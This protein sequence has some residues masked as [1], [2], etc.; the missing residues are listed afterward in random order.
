V[1]RQNDAAYA[2][3]RLTQGDKEETVKVHGKL[4]SNDGQ[5][6]IGWALDGHGI[7]MRA[8]WDG[9]VFKK[10]SFSPSLAGL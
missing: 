6:T 1:L 9:Q 2:N 10:W 8:E 7:L 5:V 3:W 4:S